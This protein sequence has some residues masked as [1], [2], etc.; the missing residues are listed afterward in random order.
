MGDFIKTAAEVSAWFQK[1][2]WKEGWQVKPDESIDK[3]VFIR[4][5]FANKERWKKSFRFLASQDLQGMA[6]GR[7]ELEGAD[8]YVNISEYTTKNEEDA[9]C[10]AHIKYIDIQYLIFGEEKI[11]VLPL[12]DTKDATPYDAEKDIYFMKPDY[13]KYYLA[14]AGRFFIFFPDDAHRPSVKVAENALVRK[15]IVKLKI[16]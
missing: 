9:K 10:E 1:G 7:Y 3:E 13:D 16:D 6:L 4:H 8:L 14:D 11:G 5:Y 12:S 15:A 2:E